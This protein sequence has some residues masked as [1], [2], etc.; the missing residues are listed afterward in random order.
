MSIDT[1]E[2]YL[3]FMVDNNIDDAKI[4]EHLAR[5]DST[6]LRTLVSRLKVVDEARP[7]RRD[8]ASFRSRQS[9]LKGRV[10]E[11]V[12]ATLVKGV[13]CFQ[14]WQR[15]TTSTNEIDILILLGP[16]SKHVPALRSWDTHYVCE[17]KY[18]STY[19]KNDWVS[20]LNTVMQTHGTKVGLLVSRK[21]IQNSGNG[22]KVRNLLQLLAN[23]A[24]PS[25]VLTVDWRDFEACANGKNFLQLLS[26]RFVE[27][28]T[29]SQKLS[30]LAS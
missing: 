22:A 30:L 23:S 8:A 11:Q 6:R 14:S 20:K 29:G 18:H 5:V 16:T 24:Q 21:G 19:V 2:A 13:K 4:Y 1:L 27:V 26:E 28:R 25:F 9:D 12:V 3:D 7:P 17:C 10:Y 15:V